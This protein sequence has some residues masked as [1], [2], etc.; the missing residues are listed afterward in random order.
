[1]NRRGFLGAM[2]KAG[3]S[4]MVLPTATTY[5]RK[6]VKSD[7]LFLLGDFEQFLEPIPW[8]SGIN[9]FW[10]QPDTT[11]ELLGKYIQSLKLNFERAVYFEP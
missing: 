10:F 5:A 6:W 3:V 1:M 2:L 4:A 8:P 11:S 9:P 7:S